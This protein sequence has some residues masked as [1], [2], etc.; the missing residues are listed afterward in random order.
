[1]TI[2]IEIEIIILDYVKQ[3]KDFENNKKRLKLLKL[4]NNIKFFIKKLQKFLHISLL[5][6]LILLIISTIAFFFIITLLLFI[7]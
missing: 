4:H 6:L 2:P 3:I 1:M 5:L 7:N